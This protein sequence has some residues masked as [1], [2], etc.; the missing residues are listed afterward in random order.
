MNILKRDVKECTHTQTHRQAQEN[1]HTHTWNE[2][3]RNPHSMHWHASTH[4][5]M[6]DGAPVHAH[7]CGK[8]KIIM[9]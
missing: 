7:S 9:G 8:F 1:R 5:R 3:C 4:R 2:A 6:Y